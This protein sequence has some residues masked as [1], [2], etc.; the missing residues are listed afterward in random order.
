MDQY[1]V[2]INK[3]IEKKTISSRIKYDLQDVMDLRV[4]GWVPRRDKENSQNQI[5]R[6]AMQ[7]L[8]CPQDKLQQKLRGGRGI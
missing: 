8:A 3:I 1:F 7:E 5:H 2:R 6:K 4:R